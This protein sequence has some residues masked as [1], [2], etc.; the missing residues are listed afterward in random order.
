MPNAVQSIECVESVQPSQ[1]PPGDYPG[2][3][4]GY[5]VDA[6]IAGKTYRLKTS[7]GVR[8]IGVPCVVRVRPEGVTVDAQ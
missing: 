4:G 6:R 2:T 1:L 7:V 3:W 5:E 8:G